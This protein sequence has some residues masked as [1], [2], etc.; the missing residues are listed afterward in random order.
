MKK[1]KLLLC[2]L[3]LSIFTIKAQQNYEDLV[4]LKNGSII[5]GIII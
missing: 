3:C 5:R 1:I 4:F 2:L